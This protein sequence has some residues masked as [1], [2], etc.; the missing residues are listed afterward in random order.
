MGGGHYP[1]PVKNIA[2]AT[3][4]NSC[5]MPPL[6][7]TAMLI[8]GF[9]KEFTSY[10]KTTEVEELRAVQ[11]FDAS[12]ADYET[13]K[14]AVSD[15]KEAQNQA[16]EKYDYAAAMYAAVCAYI[17]F[18][19]ERYEVFERLSIL[20]ASLINEDYKKL[21]K[22]D[23]AES[24]KKNKTEKIQ[25]YY[26]QI[27]IDWNKGRY[28]FLNK[29]AYDTAFRLL[30]NDELAKQ[31]A[32]KI[33]DIDTKGL[34]LADKQNPIAW[35][36]EYAHLMLVE[37]TQAKD[38][39]DAARQAT[40]DAIMY[41]NDSRHDYNKAL[42]KKNFYEKKFS[43]AKS[44]IYDLRNVDDP[45]K[46]HHLLYANSHMSVANNFILSDTQDDNIINAKFHYKLAAMYGSKA[47]FMA[48]ANLDCCFAE[49]YMLAAS[50]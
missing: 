21:I 12:E 20:Y 44:Y 41:L 14:R 31:I 17:N 1:Q 2:A 30:N 33:V 19:S 40:I 49:L 10:L 25:K 24:L 34:E 36:E 35:M 42:T 46:E 47:A 37:F 48:L 43:S 5:C 9:K 50:E 16:E 6:P 7:V 38:I 27:M 23:N 15:C 45:N 3:M 11:D 22:E 13:A 32:N 28:D 18:D 39:R 4:V 26:T 29:I 8:A